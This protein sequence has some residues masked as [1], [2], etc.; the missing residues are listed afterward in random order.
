MRPPEFWRADVQGRDAAHALRALLTPVSWVYAWAAANRIRTA[1]PRHA[2]VPVVCIGNLTVGGAGKTPVTRALRAKLGAH[3]HTLSRGYGGRI[4]GPL[5]VTPDM[6]ASEVGD[7]PL[8]HAADG[9]AWIARDRVAG[10]LAAAQAGAQ[11]ILMDDGFQ[12]PSLAKDVSLVVV[13]PAFGIGN[14]QVFPAGP[15]RERLSD[16]LGRADAIVLMHNPPEHADLEAPQWLFDFERP[17]LHA[18]LAPTQSAP[19]GKLIAFAGLAR[20]EKFFDTLD[21]IGADVDEAV[22]YGDH[23]AFSEDDLSFLTQLAQERGA[24]L[25]TT[26][27]DAARLTPE[28]RQR[29]AVLPVTARFEDDAALDAL[30]TP[31]RSRMSGLHG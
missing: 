2:P 4:A 20:P 24:R 25:I 12:N 18:A 14:G 30:L 22:P 29:V 15:L 21:A 11:A 9:P 27:K 26:E 23:H 13:D 3:A 19:A 31:I 8:L 28:W 17:I 7:E 6:S 10:A 1:L 16:G 5:R